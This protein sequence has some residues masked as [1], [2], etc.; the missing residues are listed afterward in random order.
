MLEYT[1]IK[2]WT[3]LLRLRYLRY[4]GK[5][6]CLKRVN[7]HASSVNNLLQFLT[8]SSNSPIIR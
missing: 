1:E 7:A 6:I 2:T 4:W 8:N 5:P 3:L